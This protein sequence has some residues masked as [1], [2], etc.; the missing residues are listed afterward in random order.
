MRVFSVGQNRG[1]LTD[2]LV[3]TGGL[4]RDVL[5]VIGGAL[6]VALSA[7][8]SV[9]LWFTP[10]PITGQTLA[11][12]LVGATGGAGRGSLSLGVYVAG[13]AVGLPFFSG[14]GL[15]TYGYLAGFVV[16]AALIGFLAD[17]GWDRT[18]RRSVLA[19]LSGNIVIYLLGIPW[20]SYYLG[21][22]LMDSLTAG[23]TPF[24]PGDVVKL[25]IAASV[26]PS[27]WRLTLRRSAPDRGPGSDFPPT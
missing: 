6:F 23:L 8:I 5:F 19:M 3:P 26:L 9:P 15:A 2:Q 25:V 17:R 1:T 7:Q 4:L 24:I 16:A 12:L 22:D 21:L 27:A 11:V 20:L 13:G 10:V 18:Y 14:A